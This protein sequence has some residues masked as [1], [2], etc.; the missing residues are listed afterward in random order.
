M[1]RTLSVLLAA[2]VVIIAG[3]SC[4]ESLP[5]Y[6]DP[7]DVFDANNDALYA[8]RPS[9]NSLKAF[10]NI[11]NIFDDTFEDRA[12]VEGSLTIE[13]SGNSSV[14]K[15]FR[16]GSSAI[17]SGKYNAA[18]NRLTIGPNDTLKFGVSWNFITDSGQNIRDIVQYHKDPTCQQRWVSDPL[19]FFVRSEVKVF[20]RTGLVTGKTFKITFQHH[21]EYFSDQFC[22]PLPS[23]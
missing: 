19:T 1:M 7:A 15:T 5:M 20:E 11:V 10:I 2:L 21:R 6:R 14:R 9:D 13:W 3:V 8:I 22:T 12:A 17:I 4:D 16:L 23:N 18:S